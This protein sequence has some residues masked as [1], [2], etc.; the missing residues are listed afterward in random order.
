MGQKIV[1]I[2]LVIVGIGAWIGDV[3]GVMWQT[4]LL[5]FLLMVVD[6]ISGMLAAKKE[7]LEH[8]D[9][10]LYGLLVVGGGSLVVVFVVYQ[11]A[12][13]LTWGLGELA[14][15]VMMRLADRLQRYRLFLK[16]RKRVE[17]SA[18]LV[19]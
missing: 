14:S 4:L 3:F 19:A 15:L 7:A 8:P 6:Y 12:M 5:L 17:R 11:P 2:K 9:N 10:C 16:K 1:S 13:W 18:P